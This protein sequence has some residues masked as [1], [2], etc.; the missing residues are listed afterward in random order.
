MLDTTTGTERVSPPNR[1]SL[2]AALWQGTPFLGEIIVG[3]PLARALIESKVTA[4]LAQ[5]DGG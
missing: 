3:G 1:G 2:P 4:L 5:E